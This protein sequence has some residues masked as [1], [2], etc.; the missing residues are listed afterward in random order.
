MQIA[1]LLKSFLFV[2]IQFAC[3]FLIGITGPLFPANWTLLTVEVAGVA[4]G[5]WAILVMRVGNFNIAPDLFSWTVLVTTGPY[6][7]IRHPMYLA[8]LITTIPLVI[9]HF[10][11]A[12]LV[13]WLLLL[14]DLVLK[15]NYEE[16]ILIKSLTGYKQYANQSYRLVPFLY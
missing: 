15:L 2:A 7:L 6:R 13:I 3:L 8:L 14:L 12:R 16:R 10:T 4:L 5:L 11:L 9:N 1:K